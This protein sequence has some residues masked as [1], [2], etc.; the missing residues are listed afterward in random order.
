MKIMLGG[1][2]VKRAPQLCVEMF[3]VEQVCLTVGDINVH[4]IGARILN[5]AERSKKLVRKKANLRQVS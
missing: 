5:R 4:S 3:V 1:R 2:V